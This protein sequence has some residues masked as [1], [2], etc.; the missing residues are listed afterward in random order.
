[1]VE[2]IPSEARD[3]NIS[4]NLLRGAIAVARNE[5]VARHK[6]PKQTRSMGLLRPDTFGVGARN[7]GS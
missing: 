1:M 2:F 6:V 7:D 5:V 3:L 4:A